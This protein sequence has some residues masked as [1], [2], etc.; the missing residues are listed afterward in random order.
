MPRVQC[1]TLHLEKSL[2]SLFKYIFF[3]NFTTRKVIIHRWRER[4]TDMDSDIMPNPSFNFR[5]HLNTIDIIH[6]RWYQLHGSWV[7]P[8]YSTFTWEYYPV[9][10][11]GPKQ[12]E[13][14]PASLQTIYIWQN[15]LL[16]VFF[17]FTGTLCFQHF[18]GR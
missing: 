8:A 14:S 4:E 2:I 11:L 3:S 6:F 10:I 5:N 9:R 1:G 16:F 17:R 7:I 12:T 18:I 15:I 13:Y